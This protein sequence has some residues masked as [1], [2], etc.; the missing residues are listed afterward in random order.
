MDEVEDRE[1]QQVCKVVM[2]IV[3]ITYNF[4]KGLEN[5]L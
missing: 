1:A 5:R 2:I 4:S 3:I